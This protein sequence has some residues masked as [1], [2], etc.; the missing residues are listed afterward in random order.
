M[1]NEYWGVS[2]RPADL[3]PAGSLA[4]PAL[5]ARGLLGGGGVALEEEVFEAAV[6]PQLVPGPGDR[7]PRGPE[8]GGGGG[9]LEQA[10]D[11]RG[12]LPRV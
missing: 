5:P 6:L 1:S 2:V 3:R 7:R 9:R 4:G 8:P 12:R 10:L 11:G